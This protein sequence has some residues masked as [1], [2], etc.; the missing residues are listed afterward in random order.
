MQRQVI[1]GSILFPMKQAK[2]VLAFY[3]EYEGVAPDDLYLSAA[4]VSNAEL[5]GISGVGF[6]VCYSGPA[7]QADKILAKLRSA[8]HTGHGWAEARRL[9]GAAEIGR[10]R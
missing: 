6:N 1:G 7:N 5:S 2:S 10:W 4:L 3:S 9:C 8:G